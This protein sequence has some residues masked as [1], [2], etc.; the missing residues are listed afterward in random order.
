MRRYYTLLDGPDAAACR[1]ELTTIVERH[2]ARSPD[3]VRPRS[4]RYTRLRHPRTWRN[5]P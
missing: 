4:V 1:A 2:S 5:T 3:G